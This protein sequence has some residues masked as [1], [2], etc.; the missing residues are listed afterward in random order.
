[1]A[2]GRLGDQD[3]F[4]GRHEDP[5]GG[6]RTLVDG[7]PFLG[8]ERRLHL[9]KHFLEPEI[10]PLARD[11]RRSRLDLMAPRSQGGGEGGFRLLY[12]FARVGRR[13]SASSRRHRSLAPALPL[14]ASIR[15]R[16]P[17]LRP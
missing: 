15:I 5:F 3:G 16:R 13:H 10:D 12:P 17:L 6:Q 4:A 2:V 9:P 8:G 11:D 7:S 14:A 1:M